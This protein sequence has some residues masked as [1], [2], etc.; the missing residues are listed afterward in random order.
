MVARP[1]KMYDE[2]GLE[3]DLATPGHVIYQALGGFSRGANI[4]YTF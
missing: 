4:A 2:A 3:V 1:I